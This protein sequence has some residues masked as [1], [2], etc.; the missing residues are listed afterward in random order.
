MLTGETCIN[1][2]R[3]YAWF[4]ECFHTFTVFRVKY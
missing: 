2:D 4:I 1:L 3:H